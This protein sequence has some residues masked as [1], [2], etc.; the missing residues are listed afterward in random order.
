MLRFALAVIWMIFL[1][2]CTCTTNF[3]N[4]VLHYDISFKFDASPDWNQLFILPNTDV[5]RDHIRWYSFQKI[6][7]FT[8]FAILTLILTNMGQW[9]LGVIPAVGYAIA[10]EILQLYFMR[11]GRIVDMFIDSSGILLA[12]LFVVLINRRKPPRSARPWPL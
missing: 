7:H 6:G 4:M 11:D 10:T 2:I 9:R 12:Y 1:F 5:I 3:Q 8:G